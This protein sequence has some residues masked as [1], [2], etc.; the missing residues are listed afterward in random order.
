MLY[1]YTAWSAPPENRILQRHM[2]RENAPPH[3]FLRGCH[4]TQ[5][6]KSVRRHCVSVPKLA[7]M[8]S[9]RLVI[10]EICCACTFHTCTVK[11]CEAD[12]NTD[13]SWGQNRT[14]ATYTRPCYS[15]AESTP[16][17]L[18]S[19]PLGR[20][21]ILLRRYRHRAVNTPWR[22]SAAGRGA[23]ANPL[24]Q[25]P[26]R[27]PHSRWTACVTGAATL[28][29]SPRCSRRRGGRRSSHCSSHNT[30]RREKQPP[31][32]PR[33]R[34]STSPRGCQSPAQAQ[35]TFRGTTTTA[36]ARQE[37]LQ[38]QSRALQPVRPTA[39]APPCHRR[40]AEREPRLFFRS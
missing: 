22:S 12:A 31:P 26:R 1:S 35:T 13:A 24:R 6:A 4:A 17:H 32:S 2:H 40:S 25:H 3:S 7:P 9:R 8:W 29:S 20:D 36:L 14:E 15:A 27:R 30:P 39:A 37:A 16:P 23:G 11:S 34:H 33:E 19:M 5:S 28:R 10:G 18:H 21:R 38:T